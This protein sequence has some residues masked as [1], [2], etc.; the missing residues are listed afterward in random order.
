MGLPTVQFLGVVGWGLLMAWATD[1]HATEPPVTV[2][3][4]TFEH[5]VL[6]DRDVQTEWV[7]TFRVDPRPVS[8]A[9]YAA[10]VQA[11]PAWR[12]SALAG[13]F[14]DG[15]YL[16]H[17]HSDLEPNGEPDAPVVHVSWYAAR[18][19]CQAREGALPTLVQWEY[20]AN[21]WRTLNEHSDEDYA[22]AVF[23]WYGEQRPT[24]LRDEALGVS[25]FIGPVNEWLE[26]YQLLLGNGDQID[27]GGGSCGDTGRLIARYDSAHYAT[28]LRYQMRSNISPETTASNQGFRCVYP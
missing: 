20:L 4:G 22:N 8:R 19:Y 24:A 11:H 14:Q 1:A 3:E 21:L 10:F 25:G 27:F 2:P 26:D 18:A 23:A 17:W 7:D 12:R 6:L 9:D 13:L 15:G 16:K 28:L 5:A